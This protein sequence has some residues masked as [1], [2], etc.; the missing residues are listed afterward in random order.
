MYEVKNIDISRSLN[1]WVKFHTVE[2]FTKKHI[3]YL[4]MFCTEFVF[5]FTKFYKQE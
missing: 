4:Y 1:I 3:I 5:Y 2:I